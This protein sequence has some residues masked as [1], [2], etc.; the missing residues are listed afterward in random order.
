MSMKFKQAERLQKLPPY[1]FV[2]LEQLAAQKKAE[3]VKMIDFGIGDP[4]LPCP[5]EIV[6]AMKKAADVNENQKYSSS[7]G[8]KDLR[9]AIAEY[10]KKRF[11]VKVNPDTEVCVTIGS[12]EGIYNIA[13]AFV[14]DGEKIIAPNPGYP[15]YSGAATL[16]NN[17]VCDKITLKKEN[18]WLLDVKECPTD[19]KLMYINYPNNPTG[20]TADLDYVK[21]VYKWAKRNKT[22][23]AY[24]NAYCEMTYDGYRAPSVLQ[25][26]KDA[27][28]FMS[29]SKTFCM[30]GFRLGF[31]VGNE[32]LVSGLTKCK[33]QI[34]SGAPIFIQKAAITALQMYTDDGY[35]KESVQKNM[36][37][38]G[39]RRKVL[40][41]GLN[42]LG[43]ECDMPK[44]TF[45]VWFDC[46]KTS[47]EF[48]QEMIDKGVIV[49]PGTGFGGAC[50]GYIRMAVTKPVDQIQEAL[51]RMGKRND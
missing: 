39:E 13:Q 16:F 5:G 21:D 42:E 6:R 18:E 34:D 1:L 32:E 15:V 11:N 29:F 43:Y 12:K 2:R 45:Y 51:R 3:G 41:E 40:V 28:E 14:N 23:L 9:E 33:G 30:T 31:A 17:A 22:I 20:A 49:T 27:I 36:D 37:E 8:E 44:G 7:K 10:Y 48:T 4:D 38:F 24:D 26:G 19:A 50:E 47:M 46:G 35:L 25:A